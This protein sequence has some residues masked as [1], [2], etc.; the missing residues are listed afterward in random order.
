MRPGVKT[1]F[2]STVAAGQPMPPAKPFSQSDGL[3]AEDIRHGLAELPPPAKTVTERSSL[4]PVLT[5]R[6]GAAFQATIALQRETIKKID[7]VRSD[8]SDAPIQVSY[9]FET[10]GL[11]FVVI[12]RPTRGAAASE[13]KS[14][15]AELKPRLVS[16][17]NAMAEISADFGRRYA[18]LVNESDAIR[19]DATVALGNASAREVDAALVSARQVAALK[20][21]LD[22][23][24]DYRAA[25]FEPGLSPEQRRL[26]FGGALEKLDLP[27]P[28]GEFQPVRRAASW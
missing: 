13:I 16:V 3:L 25:V 10:D 6:V 8:L 17:Q 15:L 23:Y 14:E 22:G 24:R 27:L 20:D 12:P 7:A 19:R 28:R 18:E 21:S 26:L 2:A 9:S 11:K 5:E 4:P 1:T